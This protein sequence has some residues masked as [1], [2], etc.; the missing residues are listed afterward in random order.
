MWERLLREEYDGWWPF[1]GSSTQTELV[2]CQTETPFKNPR[3][4]TEAIIVIDS[5]YW[6]SHQF[7]LSSSFA[8]CT[9][10]HYNIIVVMPT[11]AYDTPKAAKE[12]TTRHHD[13]PN[14]YVMQFAYIRCRIPAWLSFNQLWP[15]RKKLKIAKNSKFVRRH[16]LEIR[17][18]KC[19]HCLS[20]LLIVSLNAS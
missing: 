7:S 8:V 5:L 3:S 18:S 14:N 11:G 13:N 10:M 20:A 15:Q 1:F 6:L 19:D 4:A 17:K 9:C 16:I 2:F 12:H